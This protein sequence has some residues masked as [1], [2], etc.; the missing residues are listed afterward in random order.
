MKF[1]FV[2]ADTEIENVNVGHVQDVL[3]HA[4]PSAISIELIANSLRCSSQEVENFLAELER[5]KI[6][7]RDPNNDGQWLRVDSISSA[8]K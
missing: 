8:C 2:E 1:Q 7:V 5:K 3:E 6:A 4:F